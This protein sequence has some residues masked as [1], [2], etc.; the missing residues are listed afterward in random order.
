LRQG[1]RRK[2]RH[3]KDDVGEDRRKYRNDELHNF[4]SSP[5]TFSLIKSRRM[6][7]VRHVAHNGEMRN[8]YK[9]VVGNPEGR[10]H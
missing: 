9:I 1:A 2:F 5:N 8:M 3:K 7:W 6:R 10:D 4:C